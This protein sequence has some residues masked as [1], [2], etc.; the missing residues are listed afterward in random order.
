MRV[1]LLTDV[2]IA[3]RVSLLNTI[4]IVSSI[5][6]HQDTPP[7]FS[8]DSPK[9]HSCKVILIKAVLYQHWLTPCISYHLCH[10]RHILE[11]GVFSFDFCSSRAGFYIRWVNTSFTHS[12]QCSL[13]I[14]HCNLVL[15]ALCRT[16]PNPGTCAMLFQHSSPSGTFHTWSCSQGFLHNCFKET[17]T[18]F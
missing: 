12:F 3:S 6:L 1:L 7:L 10:N 5:N 8:L 11:K 17:I 9:V 2:S 4:D 16:A 14:C 18:E 13:C 15:T